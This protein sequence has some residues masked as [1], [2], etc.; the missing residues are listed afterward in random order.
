VIFVAGIVFMVRFYIFN[1]Y[2]VVGQSME[3]TFHEN[4]FIIVDKISQRNRSFHRGDIVVFVP[5][6]KDIPYIKRVIGLP[7]ETVE[8]ANGGVNICRPTSGSQDLSCTKL[9]ESY[10]PQGVLTEARC[11]ITNFPVTTGA[12]FVL[13]DNREYSTD[14]RCCFG[15]GCYSGSQYLVTKQYMIG[16]VFMRVFPD[17][18][19][20]NNEPDAY[21]LSASGAK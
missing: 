2:S 13:G 5:P 3:P 1:P 9:N 21:A 15:L 11:G 14:S 20:F 19:L 18:K 8:I 12:L 6:G 17:M 10:I 4:D 16:K 7:G